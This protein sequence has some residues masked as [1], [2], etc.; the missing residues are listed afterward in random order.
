M[1]STCMRLKHLTE[2]LVGGLGSLFSK[3][4][5]LTAT[6][7]KKK[8]KSVICCVHTA[9][10]GKHIPFGEASSTSLF[11]VISTAHRKADSSML[12]REYETNNYSRNPLTQTALS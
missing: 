4:E 7:Q 1:L 9:Q 2:S 11:A 3:L 8:L 5:S 12:L 6:G 10:C